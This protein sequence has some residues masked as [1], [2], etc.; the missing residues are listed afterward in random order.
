MFLGVLIYVQLARLFL[1]RTPQSCSPVIRANSPAVTHL[2]YSALHSVYTIS[3]KT[4]FEGQRR[5]FQIDGIETVEVCKHKRL[6]GVCGAQLQVKG[7]AEPLCLGKHSILYVC[8]QNTLFSLLTARTAILALF[9]KVCRTEKR[10]PCTLML[11]KERKIRKK[12]HIMYDGKL[13]EAVVFRVPTTFHYN[14]FFHRCLGRK[15]LSRS[16][17]ESDLLSPFMCGKF[18]Y[19][20]HLQKTPQIC[21]EKSPWT[22]SAFSL[23]I[24][25]CLYLVS[26]TFITCHCH[27]QAYVPHENC[28]TSYKYICIYEY[29]CMYNHLVYFRELNSNSMCNCNSNRQCCYLLISILYVFVQNT[30]DHMTHLYIHRF[31]V[32]I[33]FH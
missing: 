26:Y 7:T 18:Q 3:Y 1:P 4:N 27:T 10:C 9:S 11:G 8:H 20:Q 31:R 13:V 25:I 15:G 19:L 16:L 29:V 5:G 23:F 21:Q 22:Q 30:V 33:S 2:H 6:D 24:K 28:I 32:A 17:S 14:R 12:L